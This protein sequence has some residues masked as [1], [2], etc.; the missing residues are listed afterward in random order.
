MSQSLLKDEVAHLLVQ[1][2]KTEASPTLYSPQSHTHTDTQL[3]HMLEAARHLTLSFSQSFS[4]FLSC[5]IPLTLFPNSFC[6]PLAFALIYVF[7]F[8]RL[9]PLKLFTVSLTLTARCPTCTAP[10]LLHIGKGCCFVSLTCHLMPCIKCLSS[11]VPL[12]S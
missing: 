5:C 12:A 6:F 3:Y 7:F 9:L 1:P 11:Q 10:L 2:R 4:L 8:S